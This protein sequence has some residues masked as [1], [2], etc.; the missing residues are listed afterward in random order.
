[1]NNRYI[2]IGVGIVDLEGVRTTHQERRR[3]G[4]FRWFPALIVNYYN[5]DDNEYEFKFSSAVECGEAHEKL[6]KALTNYAQRNGLQ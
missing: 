6:F 2:D 5:D 4:L 3:S 1:M